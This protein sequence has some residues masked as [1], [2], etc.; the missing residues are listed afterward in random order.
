M[1]YFIQKKTS[2][3]IAVAK[4]CQLDLDIISEYSILLLQFLKGW[5]MRI[6]DFSIIKIGYAFR[7]SMV[8]VPDGDV[9]VIQPK[10]ITG[11]GRIEFR[12]GEPLRV[13]VSIS[14]SLQRGEVLVVNRGRFAASVFDPPDDNTWIVTSSILVVDITKKSILP[15]YIACYL[16]SGNGQRLFRRHYE[17]T[18]VPFI[19]RKNLGQMDIP[20]PSVERQKSL[21]AFEKTAKKY[22]RLTTRKHELLIEILNNELRSNG[23][24]KTMKGSRT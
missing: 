11:D 23:S 9:K 14:S 19:S 16:N 2:I 1:K 3:L 4:Y 8:N 20:I 17:Q 15:E 22:S 12:D 7:E 5:K 18:T 13:D 24:G 10:N 21:I 6:K